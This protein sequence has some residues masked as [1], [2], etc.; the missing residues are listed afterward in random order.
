MS[1]EGNQSWWLISS[2]ASAAG[3]SHTWQPRTSVSGHVSHTL[4]RAPHVAAAHVSQKAARGGRTSEHTSP[5]DP[6]V[7]HDPHIPHD[8]HVPPTT[9]KCHVA[10]TCH[11]TK[12]TWALPPRVAL[13][14]RVWLF[15]RGPLPTCA[16]LSPHACPPPVAFS[17]CWLAP[18]G[19]RWATHAGGEGH[20]WRAPQLAHCA[21][22]QQGEG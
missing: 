2:T 19:E 9:H 21:P 3:A 16:R 13:S 20:P 15:P 12:H 1:P 10:Y 8:P 17:H 22:N 6:H 7:A 5:H 4:G 18:T 11:T 14:P